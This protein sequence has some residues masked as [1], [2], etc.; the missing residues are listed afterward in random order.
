MAVPSLR[1]RTLN[2]APFRPDRGY[3]LYWMIAARRTHW[4][5]A[6][7][8]A[9]ELAKELDRPL[10]VLEALR[11]GHR[12]ASDRIHR[13]VL[14]G[15]RENA[16][17]FEVAGVP[18]HPYVEPE[19][20]A[21]RGLLSA[22]AEGAC[23]VVTD[24]FPGFFLPRMVASAGRRLPVRLE[25]VDSNGL[26]PL[27]A[28][29]RV[30]DRAVDFRRFLQRELPVHLV[31][32]P[33]THPLTTVLPRLE[34]LPAEVLRCWPAAS[35]ELLAGRLPLSSF[36]I[37]HLVPPVPF[38]GGEKAA[39]AALG[40]FVKERLPLYAEGRNEPARDVASGLSPY[41]H[42]G[43]VSAHQVLDLL[44]RAEG[45]SVDREFPKASGKREGWWGMSGNA[46][47]F[48]DQL[49]TW[50]ELGLNYAALRDDLTAYASLPAWARG[51][52]A[53]H[54]GDPRAHLYTLDQLERAATHDEIWN[55]AQRQLRR[56]GRIHGYL[57]ML[58][59]KN[60][61]Q[62]SPSPEEAAATLVAL[63]DRWAIDGRDP[64]SY[65]GI[66]WTFGRYD[67]PW[68]ERPVLGTVRAMTSDSTRRKL[69]VGPYLARF[70]G[71]AS[72]PLA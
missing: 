38:E 65:S 17:A 61:L 43:H 35:P 55:A 47:A 67:R 11:C 72:L 58:W 53:A 51:T 36:P 10:V 3:V 34:C 37:D 27:R 56:E 2:D 59:A 1:I 45:W 46:E 49:V 54:R 48:L 12:W 13:F 70:S 16:R 42:F 40:R 52:L 26:L 6:L 20:G 30:F 28:T 19:A 50:R 9:V 23:A 39:V 44:A 60:V 31:N 71:Q 21:G 32:R 68:P 25:A 15:M 63:N 8:R 66:F 29:G 33:R 69:D 14:D 41:L 7:D 62:W 22:L 18:Y 64:N 4:N 24:D 57:R 5:F